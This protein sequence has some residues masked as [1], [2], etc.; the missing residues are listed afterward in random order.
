MKSFSNEQA[1]KY[2]DG[3]VPYLKKQTVTEI[4]CEG[5]NSCLICR[6]LNTKE[7]LNEKS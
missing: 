4:V 5:I 2:P 7:K 3:Y 6:M 1:L